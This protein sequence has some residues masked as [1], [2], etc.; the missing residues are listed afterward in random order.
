[1]FGSTRSSCPSRTAT[2]EQSFGLGRPESMR[3]YLCSNLNRFRSIIGVQEQSS[4]LHVFM[5]GVLHGLTCLEAHARAAHLYGNRRA[6]FR[7]WPTGI[8]A[9]LLLHQFELIPRSNGSVEAGH[10]STILSV[11]HELCP[12]AHAQ[13][14]V[15]SGNGRAVFW[16][17]LI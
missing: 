6:V 14:V 1:M 17:W 16:I 12:E 10:Q 3:A 8:D 4:S 13:L 15:F 2:D 9:S 7:T 5:L 11:F